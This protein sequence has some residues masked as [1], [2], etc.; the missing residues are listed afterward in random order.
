MPT[1]SPSEPK[2]PPV[3]YH[4]FRE[5]LAGG[6]RTAGYAL[7]LSVRQDIVGGPEEQE[8]NHHRDFCSLY[9]VQRGQGFHIIDQRRYAVTR[10]DVYVMGPG[11]AHYFTSGENLSTLTAHFLPS[12][13][14][15]EERE[16]LAA[17]PGFA[18]LFVTDA[19]RRESGVTRTVGA[20]TEGA[21]AS[22]NAHPM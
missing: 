1:L 14:T 16:A 4:W 5:V 21:L 6:E 19:P 20:A 9:L 8:T 22:S 3:Y 11:M 10:G 12:L 18:A 7:P 17:L 2:S 13:F 15:T